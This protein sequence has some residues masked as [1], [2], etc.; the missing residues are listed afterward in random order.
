MYTY[1]DYA[2]LGFNE[3]MLQVAYGGGKPTARTQG[4]RRFNFKNF[5]IFSYGNLCL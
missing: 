4:G 3:Q 1:S 5:F 2:N